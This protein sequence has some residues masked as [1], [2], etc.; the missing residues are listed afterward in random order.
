MSLQLLLLKKVA[1]PQDIS[2]L[3]FDE[4]LKRIGRDG[5]WGGSIELAGLAATLNQQ[6]FVIR[7]FKN[8]YDIRVFG[9][10]SKSTPLALWFANRHYQ[11]L[12]GCA[13]E[14]AGQ[15]VKAEIGD[16]APSVGRAASSFGGCTA[17]SCLGGCTQGSLPSSRAA[18]T[19]EHQAVST[20]GR[21]TVGPA[22]PSSL[23]GRTQRSS[24]SVFKRS[25]DDGDEGADADPPPALSASQRASLLA[26]RQPRC[27][28]N[29][30]AVDGGPPRFICQFCDYSYSH[31]SGTV[32]SSA[33]RAH[34][35]RWHDGAGLPGSIKATT[36]SFRKL[37]AQEV[38]GD[39]FDW[40]CPA[41]RFGLPTHTKQ[42]MS[43]HVLER[44]KAVHRSAR[45]PEYDDKQWQAAAAREA[46]KRR[47]SRRV[48]VATAANKR[49]AKMLLGSSEGEFEGFTSLLWP[50]V[51]IYRHRPR[52]IVWR[53][54]WSCLLCHHLTTHATS[55]A[56]RSHRCCKFR[57]RK[58]THKERCKRY[59]RAVRLLKKI[60]H[61]VP[62]EIAP[63]SDGRCLRVCTMNI[64]KSL[65]SKVPAVMSTMQRRGLDL[66]CIQEAD[67]NAVSWPRVVSS[68][69]AQGFHVVGGPEVADE[70]STRALRRCVIVSRTPVRCLTPSGI[71]DPARVAVAVIEV[72]L[73]D[74]VRKVVVANTY[75]HAS[76]GGGGLRST[77]ALSCEWLLLG[78]FNV[79]L[80]EDPAALTLAA[81]SDVRSLDECFVHQ[82]AL[83]GTS[84]S[85]S[86]RLDFGLSSRGLAAV[87]LGTFEGLGNHLCTAYDIPLALPTGHS[88]PLRARLGTA[89][90][91]EAAW[92]G[93]WQPV[94]SDF[95]EALSSDID[96]AWAL[97]SSAAE[98][99]LDSGEEP[100]GRRV[101]RRCQ[102]QPRAARA[103]HKAVLGSES[104][105]LTR[106]R[107]LRRRVSHLRH[108]PLDA[109]LRANVVHDL[110]MLG[111]TFPD[112]L[113]H[114]GGAEV[115]AL[116]LVGDLIVALE[117]EAKETAVAAWRRV[118][119]DFKA[120]CSWV[121][122]RALLEEQIEL[123][124]DPIDPLLPKVAVH[125][126]CVI[127]QAETK[128]LPRWTRRAHRDPQLV[129]DALRALPARPEVS[130]DFTFT[131]PELRGIA[132]SM[133][134]RAGGPDGWV[135]EHWLLLPASFWDALAALWSVVAREHRLPRIWRL[136]RVAL[137]PKPKGGARPL[138]LLSVA[139]RLG[140]KAIGWLGHQTC[141]GVPG[142]STKDV[143][144]QLITS[145]SRGDVL[146]GQDLAKYFDSIDA[147]DV[148]VVLASLGAPSLLRG[149]VQAVYQAHY[150]LFS[151]GGLL[152]STWCLG[153]YDL[154]FLR[155]MK[156]AIPEQA[157]IRMQTTLIDSEWNAGQGQQVK[158]KALNAERQKAFL[159]RLNDKGPNPKASQV[160][161]RE[162]AHTGE[163]PPPK[164]RKEG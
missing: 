118:D 12:V 93:L 53:L 38:R 14:V 44:E 1:F 65:S 91:D 60:P 59:Y 153:T 66:L 160:R 127:S 35:V 123:D 26:L 30:L 119:Q 114:V 131:G 164:E 135:I 45:H 106:M 7:P 159:Q 79:A 83:P 124:R 69:R 78:D 85:R 89:P 151:A 132:S 57:P 51:Q 9:A 112:L 49:T 2:H 27:R 29:P 17:A 137:I 120:Q 31:A 149:L 125:P 58:G 101:A 37:S 94:A 116:R 39:A 54:A 103:V 152:G 100:H 140:M 148:D 96:A 111:S 28:N 156:E 163:T 20:L 10:P 72:R 136:S 4:Y 105:L 6:I 24:A 80:D 42:T 21:R 129:E 36:S 145:C 162:G 87:R 70:G 161:P 134:G 122:R 61:G 155:Q 50:V 63:A 147:R 40:K 107:R 121:K 16:P 154:E 130:V 158:F 73:Q 95:E 67:V 88:G 41:C 48:R 141:G 128:W 76:F 46:M 32:V 34:L 142:R 74:A 56:L 68:F 144:Q 133:K 43:K 98:A 62:E 55:P 77:I 11:A 90:V 84:P 64:E 99:A 110:E 115:G 33:R 25:R 104:L 22:A 126:V 3:G 143:I 117:R 47:S 19:G 81:R 139:H 75:G 13:E 23:G 113:D 15:A 108:V 97:L 146:V 150:K 157:K 8:D 52:G 71:S 86:R 82:G 109:S 18:P 5:S 92:M 102:W 138:T